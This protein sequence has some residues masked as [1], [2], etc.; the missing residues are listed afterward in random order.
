MMTEEYYNIESSTMSYKRQKG[1]TVGG[2][3]VANSHKKKKTKQ[4]LVKQAKL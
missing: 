4:D 1:G 3:L 2:W